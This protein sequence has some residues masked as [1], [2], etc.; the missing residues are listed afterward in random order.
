[1]VLATRGMKTKTGYW[2]GMRVPPNR[3]VLLPRQLN[4]D[5]FHFPTKRRP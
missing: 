5:H 3:N 1:M 2:Y 4:Q